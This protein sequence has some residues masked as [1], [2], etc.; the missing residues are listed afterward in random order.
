MFLVD[1]NT[2]AFKLALTF[3]L[4]TRGIPQIYYGTEIGM[5]GG[6]SHGELREEFPDG[7][8]NHERSSFSSNSR[9]VNED[10]IYC[11]VK[12]LIYLR[13]KYSSLR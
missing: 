1:G 3:I 8:P 4:T 12:N 10:Q 7:F 2:S 6:K 13:S 5:I 11:L 9:T